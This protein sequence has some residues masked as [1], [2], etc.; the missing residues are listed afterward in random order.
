MDKHTSTMPRTRL[1]EKMKTLTILVDMDDTLENLCEKWIEYL[2]H[3]HGT[4]VSYEDVRD[5]DMSKAFPTID[6]D[7]VRAPLS[8]KALWDSL[9]PLPGA[10]EN[11]RRLLSDGHKVV[12]VTASHPDTIEAK[13]NCVLFKYFPFFTLNDV[14]ITSQ[15][16]LVRGDVLV[17][18]APHNLCGGTYQGILMSA[19][20][21]LG[22]NAERHGLIRAMDWDD[23]YRI[24][25]QIAKGVMK[26]KSYYTRPV[27]HGALF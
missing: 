8:D 19:N 7:L 10:V 27:A 18:D 24:I 26:C 13:L 12:I 21:N 15:K 4:N 20:H 5:W 2:N 23:A 1:E 25:S 14:I 16:Q 11:V 9:T 3:R 17:D 22:F 6:R